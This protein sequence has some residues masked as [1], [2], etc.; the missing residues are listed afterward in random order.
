MRIYGVVWTVE[1]SMRIDLA[2]AAFVINVRGWCTYTYVCVCVYLSQH[3][4]KE[5]R[6]HVILIV[7]RFG[8]AEMQQLMI[9]EDRQKKCLVSQ[10]TKD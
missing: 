10:W 9:V 4:G 7:C 1:Q 6:V 2:I 8:E 5:H 3:L